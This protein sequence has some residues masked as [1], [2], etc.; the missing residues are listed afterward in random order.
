MPVKIFGILNVTPDSFSDGGQFDSL[1]L[2]LEQAGKLFADGADFV[3]VGGESTRPGARELEWQEEWQRLE[4]FF[5][6]IQNSNLK[7]QNFSLDTRKLEVAERFLNLG[8]QIIND[9]S[10]FQDPRMIDLVSARDG[11]AIVNHFPGN[12]IDEVHEQKISSISRVQDELLR[13]KEALI[14]AGID[15]NKIILDP[16]IG[17]GKTMDLNWELLKFPA[18]IP[19]EKV[20]IGHSKKRFLGKDRYEKEPNKKAARIAIESGAWCLRVHNVDWYC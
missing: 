8:G 1:E 19:N 14:S 4:S 15:P 20:M 9:V 18:L 3:D 10:G 2:A 6:E 17:F 7:I 11:W 13:K 5:S 16:G 12:T